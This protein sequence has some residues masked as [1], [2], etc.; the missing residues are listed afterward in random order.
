[1]A[2][3]AY[4]KGKDEALFVDGV[5][6]N[7]AAKYL[8]REITSPNFKWPSDVGQAMDLLVKAVGFES[9][10]VARTHAKRANVG[11][12]AERNEDPYFLTKRLSVVKPECMPRGIAE[13][14]GDEWPEKSRRLLDQAL[15]SRVPS[16]VQ[17]IAI[18]G[19]AG[20]GKTVL[21]KDAVKRFGGVIADVSLCSSMPDASHLV[22]GNLVVL[23]RPTLTLDAPVGHME[24]T[25]ELFRLIKDTSP[26]GKE[27]YRSFVVA[28]ATRR[29]LEAYYDAFGPLTQAL[30]HAQD[31]AMADVPLVFVMPDVESV[32]LILHSA[33]QPGISGDS[34]PRFIWD[35]VQVVDL[36]SMRVDE[37]QAGAFSYAHQPAA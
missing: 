13:V 30:H 33:L 6:V 27:A 20:K 37:V 5:D 14:L 35:A 22:A 23:D 2:A 18:V 19:G 1:M 8:L 21:A 34:G 4:F 16:K 28:N 3:S 10:H 31:P 26:K 29:N 25:Q 7:R 12:G 15:S 24:C 17:A 36:D 11:G 9:H 32:K